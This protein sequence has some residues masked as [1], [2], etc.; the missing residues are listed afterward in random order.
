M[1]TKEVVRNGESGLHNAWVPSPGEHSNKS[2]KI[3]FHL[4]P[5]ISHDFWMN[6]NINFTKCQILLIRIYHRQ[7]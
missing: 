7:Y 4:S 5:I 6:K 3:N 1:E 2:K